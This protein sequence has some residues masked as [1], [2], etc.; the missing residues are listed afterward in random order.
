MRRIYRPPV[1]VERVPILHAR[2][3]AL[4]GTTAAPRIQMLPRRKVARRLPCRRSPSWSASARAGST[5]GGG[6]TAR[7]VSPRSN[8]SIHP[9]GK[10]VQLI[11][12]TWNGLVIELDAGRIVEQ[13]DAR[14]YLAETWGVR[15]RS[16]N[17]IS[18]QCKRR[19]VKWETRRRRHATEWPDERI[20]V[21][22]DDSGSHRSGEVI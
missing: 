2:E 18:Y 21:V 9:A 7:P 10:P 6:P 15:Y 14:R 17:A 3:L 11:E 5:I 22:L 8:R 1:I 4:R 13:E 16:I 19:E 20:G 12:E